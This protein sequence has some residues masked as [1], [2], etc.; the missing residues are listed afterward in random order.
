MPHPIQQLDKRFLA[1]AL[2]RLCKL[3]YGEV[4]SCSRAQ[5][6]QK[7]MPLTFTTAG[8]RQGLSVPLRTL[9]CCSCLV[10]AL[11]KKSSFL[12]YRFSCTLHEFNNCKK[13]LQ[14]RREQRILKGRIF[15]AL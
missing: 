4:R 14:G 15:L 13:S 5:G 3:A 9:H 12:Q 11:I 7:D 1:Q 10:V 8:R 6:S 2:R